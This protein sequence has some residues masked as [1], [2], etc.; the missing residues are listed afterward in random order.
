[1]VEC[2]LKLAMVGTDMGLLAYRLDSA[3]GWLAGSLLREANCDPNVFPIQCPVEAG[4]R[5]HAKKIQI[6]F[7]R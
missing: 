4:V 3:G 1:M 5:G 6:I 2:Q 7:P